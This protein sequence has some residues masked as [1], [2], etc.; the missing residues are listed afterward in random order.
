V[1]VSLEVDAFVPVT[2][3]QLRESLAFV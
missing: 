1:P 3:E 2:E